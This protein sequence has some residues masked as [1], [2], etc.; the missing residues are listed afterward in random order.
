MNCRPLT[1]WK[2]AFWWP[3]IILSSQKVGEGRWNFLSCL[4]ESLY[5]AQMK[6]RTKLAKP[7]NTRKEKAQS[8]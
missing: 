4:E 7:Q 1:R 6:R 2:A 5:L 8:C 3:S